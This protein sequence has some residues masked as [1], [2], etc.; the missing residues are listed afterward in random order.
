M[1]SG[2]MIF[3]EK[4]SISVVT[5]FKTVRPLKNHKMPPPWHVLYW[6]EEIQSSKNVL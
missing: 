2:K 5:N 1:S 4:C 6:M 3:N